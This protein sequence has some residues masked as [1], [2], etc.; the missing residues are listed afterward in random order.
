M[1]IRKLRKNPARHVVLSEDETDLRLFPRLRGAWTRKGETHK[2]KLSGY[3]AKRVVF[4]SINVKTGKRLY[5]VTEHGAGEDFR[6]Y[7]KYVRRHYR[8]WQIVMLNDGYS[9]H[10]ANESASFA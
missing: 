4:G 6:T 8:G 7:L 2:V 9:C 10:T 1:I 3:N 5:L